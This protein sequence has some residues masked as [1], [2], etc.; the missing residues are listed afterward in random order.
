MLK[1]FPMAN[2]FIQENQ[3]S[4]DNETAKSKHKDKDK[5]KKIN[6]IINQD[7]IS[8]FN[9]SDNFTDF[10]ERKNPDALFKDIFQIKEVIIDLLTNIVGAKWVEHLDFDTIEFLNTEFNINPTSRIKRIIDVVFKINFKGNDV[11]IIII[12]EIQSTVDYFMSSRITTY[13]SLFIEHLIKSGKV[14]PG[15]LLPPIL[16]IVFYDGTK[17]WNAKNKLQDLFLKL[18]SEYKELKAFIPKVEYYLIDLSTMDKNQ[19]LPKENSLLSQMA[20][21]EIDD[22]IVQN[23]VNYLKVAQSQ[24]DNPRNLSIFRIWFKI[25]MEHK[26]ENLTL[27]DIIQEEYEMIK[28]KPVNVYKAYMERL[29]QQSRMEGLQE[30]KLEGLQEGKLETLLNLI[31][32]KFGKINSEI[33]FKIKNSTTA[34]LD[35]YLI[36]LLTASTIEDVLKI[37]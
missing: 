25:L 35:S 28:H 8:N 7:K 36:R 33:E 29:N 34:E 20:L 11:Y 1:Y 9:N 17:T 23:H 14:K 37:N 2:T 6:K 4:Y 15:Q 10:K 18:P 21:I 30:G 22:D 3:D 32:V 5:S 27:E 31:K 24:K 19:L 12:L 26:G 13:M 16:P